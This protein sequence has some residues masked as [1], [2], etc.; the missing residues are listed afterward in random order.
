MTPLMATLQVP[1]FS[2]SIHHPSYD[3]YNDSNDHYF[4]RLFF[5]NIDVLSLVSHAVPTC[6]DACVTSFCPV[7][8]H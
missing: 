2:P 4:V 1:T 3:M 5:G 8:V 6:H 7:T